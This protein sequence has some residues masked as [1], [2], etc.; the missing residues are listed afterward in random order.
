M[1]MEDAPVR[2]GDILASKYRVEHVLGAGNMG[3]VVAARH[4]TLGQVVALKFMLAGMAAHPAQRERFLREARAAVRLK[5]QHVARVLDLGTLEND[6]PYIVMEFLEG[7][8]LDARLKARGP[9]P[10]DEAVEYVLQACEAVGEAHAAGIIHRDLKPANLFLTVDV[11]GS[12]CI[13]VLDFGISKLSGVDLSLTNESQSMGSP[14][15]MSPEQI[16]SSKHVDPRSDVWS[17]GVILYQLIAGWTPFHSETIAQFCGR[18]LHG[19]PTPLGQYRSGAPPGLEA[20]ILRCLQRERERRFQSVAEL[21]A[22]IVPFAPAH[23]RAYA[24]RV[25]RA[26]GVPVNVGGGTEELLP[27]VVSPAATVP[28]LPGMQAP[29]SSSNPPIPGAAPHS[30][31]ASPASPGAPSPGYLA[32]DSTMP[33]NVPPLAAPVFG[34]PPPTTA[35]PVSSPPPMSAPQHPSATDPAWGGTGA[36]S[37]ISS[38]KGKLAAV[39]AL[40][41]GLAAAVGVTLWLLRSSAPP[42]EAEAA[43]A[44]AQSAPAEADTAPVPAA[45]ASPAASASPTAQASASTSG[46]KA[47][48]PAAEASRKQRVPAQPATTAQPVFEGV[49]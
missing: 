12:P 45:L 3:V 35:T 26:V 49:Y 24:G 17:L 14:L 29:S 41:V 32:V 47:G 48:P 25:A 36:G 11:G 20:A 38:G 4:T 44:A 23:A 7:Q 37:R 46:A 15:Y 21:A 28:L 33:L 31:G 13:K 19:A 34:A 16:G 40:V 22:A 2:P 8:D 27:G 9:L 30:R 43:P 18:V 42:P 6:A 10:F 1:S 39:A 5:S